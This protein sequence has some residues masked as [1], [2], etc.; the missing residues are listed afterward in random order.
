MQKWY[1][2]HICSLKYFDE[3]KIK[4]LKCKIK[5]IIKYFMKYLVK[6]YIT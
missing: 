5:N 4:I 1:E 6:Y 2:K 3:I